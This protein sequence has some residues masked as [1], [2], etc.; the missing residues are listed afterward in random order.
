M[1]NH[2]IETHQLTKSYGKATV[3]NQVNLQVPA[4]SIYGFLGPNG[5]GKTTTIRMLLGLLR[6]TQGQVALLGETFRAGQLS[7]Y[8][9][10]GALVEM[11]SLY[12]H[13]T[14]RENLEL[15]RRLR[16]EK[17]QQIERVLAIVDLVADSR[18]PVKQY[19]L[20]MCQRLGLAMAL[21][22][23]P[24]LLILDEPT[25][26]LDPAGIHE[27][28]VL[29]RRLPQEFGM[30]IF[31]SSHLLAEIEQIATQVGIIQKGKLIFQGS[32]ATLRA[33]Y[34]DQWWLAVDRPADALQV[35][36]GLGWSNLERQ[37]GHLA[38][39]LNGPEEAAKLNAELVQAGF[40]V[41]E[42][43]RKALSLEDI[44]LEVT[45]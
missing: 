40:R 27:M 5:A 20:G 35:A 8:Q 11:P 30:T 21:L 29:L 39:A 33:S 36:R 44:F 10:I 37:D 43:S 41:H 2:A 7:L 28:R 26:G 23:N 3:V 25:N 9:R 15:V 12:P 4:G 42:I 1:Q 38:I 24:E 31:V 32:P 34:P 22:G 6:P 18:R 17:P 19:S 45:T 14:G 13:L 16:A